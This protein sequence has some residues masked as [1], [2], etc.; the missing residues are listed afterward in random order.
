MFSHDFLG[1]VSLPAVELLFV[2]IVKRVRIRDTIIFREF[3]D[4][5]WR[6]MYHRELYLCFSG[7]CICTHST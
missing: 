7:L 2:V 3:S 1:F 4:V 6:Y 5:L